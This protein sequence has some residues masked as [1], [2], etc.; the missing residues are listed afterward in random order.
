MTARVLIVDDILTNVKLLE[1]RLN[2]EYFEVLTAMDG[3]TALEIC[4]NEEVDIVLLDVMMPGMDGFE[5]CRRLKASPRT[6]H[7]P[8][9]M[10]TALDQTS[11]KVQGLEAGAD[12]FLTKP[13]DEIALVT[14]VK[15]LTRVKTLNDEMAMRAVTG[16]RLGVD[17]D[18]AEVWQTGG[19]SG[20][21]LVVDD[22][23]RS[24]ERIAKVLAKTYDV[25]VEADPAVAINRLLE[26]P[27]DGVI[28]SLDL[29][30][31]DGL[32]FCSQ[33]RSHERTRHLPIIVTTDGDAKARLMRA[34]DMGV[35]DYVMRPIE[36]SELM[37]RVRTQVKRKRYSDYFR[38]RLEK[39][40][41]DAVIDA[42]TGLYNRRYLETHMA[43]QLRDAKK[44]GRP[45]SFV[46][47]DID[48]F[49]SVNDTFG[50]D[51]GDVVLV[52][53]ARRLQGETRGVDLAARLGGEEFVL[54]LPDS[55]AKVAFHVADRMRAGVEE[56]PFR[57][58]DAGE[59]IWVT[60]SFGVATFDGDEADLTA[61]MLVKQ[62]DQALYRAKG[63]GRNVVVPAVAA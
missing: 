32:R 19:D 34:L 44:R 53:F 21:I 27:H 30:T 13:V 15:N 4:D 24:P 11:D 3:A 28:V 1:A 39:S 36:A 48:Y 23:P 63:R 7:L 50:H 59:E 51:V 58:S 60:A 31:T 55:D 16:Q 40:V 38:S 12:D 2:A 61:E 26:D 57:I 20:R 14:R 29:Q 43:T 45:L 22:H 5:V 25:E 6:Q 49:K 52:E 56:H 9:V 8:V 41:E 18:V 62:A 54:L 37:A 17:D 46:I 33:L 47:A 42:L 10:V 35:N